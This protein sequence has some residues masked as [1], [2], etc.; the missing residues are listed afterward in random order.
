VFIDY[1]VAIIKDHVGKLFKLIYVG[2]DLNIAECSSYVIW[3]QIVMY[4]NLSDLFRMTDLLLQLLSPFN[5]IK[6]NL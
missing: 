1:K 3:K 4:L 2:N 6:G 5:S